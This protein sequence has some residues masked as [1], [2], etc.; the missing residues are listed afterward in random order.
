MMYSQKKPK[1]SLMDNRYLS[2]ETYSV[3]QVTTALYINVPSLLT[4]W[5]GL[6]GISASQVAGYRVTC[7]KTHS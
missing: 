3:S 2:W 5:T 1:V 6:H 7:P 4:T